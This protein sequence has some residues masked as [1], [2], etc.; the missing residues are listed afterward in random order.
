MEIKEV[1]KKWKQSQIIP[2]VNRKKKSDVMVSF[3]KDGDHYVY[4]SGQVKNYK[5]DTIM[6]YQ[7]HYVQDKAT[8]IEWKDIAT[9]KKYYSGIGLL[10]NICLG[11]GGEIQKAK[12]LQVK[13]R[14]TFVKIGNAVLLTISKN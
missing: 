9:D 2:V 14:F 1:S 11:L 3:T 13:G 12:K 4:G 8:R 5:F 10:N 7:E 6:E